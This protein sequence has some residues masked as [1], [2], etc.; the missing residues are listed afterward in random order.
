MDIKVPPKKVLHK[1]AELS[2]TLEYS[3]QLEAQ[4]NNF[5]GIYG[6][7]QKYVDQTFLDEIADYMPMDTGGTIELMRQ[8]TQVGSGLIQVTAPWIFFIYFGMLMVDPETG[9]PFARAG[10]IKVL[11]DI[12]LQ[13]QGAPR[14]GKLWD[15]RWAADNYDAFI[16]KLQSFTDRNL[17]L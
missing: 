16:D 10:A 6:P 3:Q 9:S 17:R 8:Q 14:R 1:S 7:L 12:E 2:V 15:V 13:Y 5:F 11:T 4:L